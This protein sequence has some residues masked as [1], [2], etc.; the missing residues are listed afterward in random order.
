GYARNFGMSDEQWHRFLTRYNVWQR[1]HYYADPENMTGEVAC[2]TPETLN[3]EEDPHADTNPA[4]GTEDRCWQVTVNLA[5]EAG[6]C[7]ASQDPGECYAS[8]SWKHGGS[9]CDTFKQ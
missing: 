5:V 9:R 1:S 4:D 8:I 6:D 2:Y 3:Y 7:S